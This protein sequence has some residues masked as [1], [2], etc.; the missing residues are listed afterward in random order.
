M[1]EEFFDN[2][3]WE[4]AATRKKVDR[5]ANEIMMFTAFFHQYME[6]YADEDAKYM[7]MKTLGLALIRQN[8]SIYYKK[9]REAVREVHRRGKNNPRQ[10]PGKANGSGR[11]RARRLV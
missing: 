5:Q 10:R 11:R 9:I 8:Q 1:I 6:Q 2:L 7:H 4:Y 3:V